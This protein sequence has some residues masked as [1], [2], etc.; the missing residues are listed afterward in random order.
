MIDLYPWLR[1]LLFRLDP[2]TAHDLVMTALAC[3]AGALYRSGP[4]DPALAT[5]LFGRKI[6][7]PIGLAAGFDK[8]ARLGDK[9]FDLGFGFVEVGGVTPRP[10]AGNP[11]PRL[12]RLEEDRAI[13]NRFGLNGGGLDAMSARLEKRDRSKGLLGVNVGAN[14][15]ST[16][17]AADYVEAIERLAHLVD[18]A[19]VNVSSP[20]TPG[21]RTLQGRDELERLLDRVLDARS[22]LGV[23]TAIVLKIAPDLNEADLDDIAAVATDRRLDAM[24]LGN[25][26]ISRPETLKSPHKGEAGGL[27]GAPL[28]E[29]STRVLAGMH[30]RVGDKVP[31]IGTGGIS[32]A[33]EAAAKLK[34]GAVAV[35]LYSAL[36][37]QGPALVARIKR[38]L[39]ALMR[40]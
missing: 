7:N 13:I 35:Q 25:T 4:D 1:P 24:I 29:L 28:F 6:S 20:N 2:E 32:S 18:F 16:D 12:F 9:L 36:I 37:Y 30:A 10:Q 5:T 23:K 21:L 26:T 27:S 22:R 39:P 11:R 19:T 15:D 8:V 17:R 33:A 40:K 38:E 3:G 14:K 34:A 31:L